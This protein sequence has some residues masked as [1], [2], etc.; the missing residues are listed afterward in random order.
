MGARACACWPRNSR[1]K[2]LWPKP[3]KIPLSPTRAGWLLGANT[4]PRADPFS[5]L[6]CSINPF[7]IIFLVP[8]R[9]FRCPGAASCHRVLAALHSAGCAGGCLPPSPGCTPAPLLHPLPQIVGALT[10]KYEPFDMIHY[11]GYIS[12]LSCFWMVAFNHLWATAAFVAMLSIGE[13]VWSPRWYDYSMA[14]APHG[15]EGIFTALVSL[16]ALRF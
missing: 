13:A 8:V 5:H 14:V 1:G 4:C 12:A 2:P 11:G 3:P 7:L 16:A 9:E 10:T 15:R 6:P